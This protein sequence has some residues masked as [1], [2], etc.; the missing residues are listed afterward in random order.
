MFHPSTNPP[1]IVARPKAVRRAAKSALAVISASIQPIEPDSGSDLLDVLCYMKD[2]NDVSGMMSLYEYFA[3]AASVSLAH[4]N[5]P[6]T[7]E[8]ASDVIEFENN[9]AWAKAYLVADFLKDV[10][11]TSYDVDRYTEIL[12]SCTIQMGNN[13]ADAVAVVNEIAGWKLDPPNLSWVPR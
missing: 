4:A 8:R 11:P 9:Q 10:R 13:F 7:R 2:E 1:Q 3:A 6:R 12:F 5:S